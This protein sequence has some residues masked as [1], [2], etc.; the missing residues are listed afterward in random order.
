MGGKSAPAPDYTA[1]AAANQYAAEVSERLGN[2]QMDMA[3]R[4]YDEMKPLAER[5]AASQIAA[6]DQQMQQAQDYYNYQV[7]TFRPIE[8]GLARDAQNFSTAGYRE[9]LARDAAAASAKAFGISQDMASR[10]A[11][12]RGINV[13]SGAGLAM[14]NQNMLGLSAQRAQAMT[15]ARTQAE[16]M[17]WARRMDVTGL[18]RNLAGASTAA[19]QGATG[20]GTSGLNTSMAPGNALAQQFGQG[21]NTTMQ[22]AQLGI[23]GAGTMLSNQVSQSNAA[24]QAEGQMYGAMLGAGATVAARSDRRLKE[25]IKLVGKDE[26][27]G[28]NL[29]E[30]KYKGG[31]GDTYIGVMADEVKVNFPEAVFTMPDGFDAV[32]YEKL[33]IEFKKV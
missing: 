1:M 16:Q 4:Q 9:Q 13:N 21:V 31:S 18:G 12:S 23:Q 11:A 14:Q 33:G 15:G 24:M 7:G 26:R 2:R 22:G 19:Y 8:Q 5:I 32:N 25:D 27:T 6:Q 28:L 30:F 20:A 3:Q 29:Y 10:A 17:G